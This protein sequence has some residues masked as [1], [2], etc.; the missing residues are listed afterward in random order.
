[1][2]QMRKRLAVNDHAQ[3]PAVRKADWHSALSRC[4]CAKNT[5]RGD[6]SVARE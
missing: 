1:M 2:D 5:S 3:L 6:P 4:S